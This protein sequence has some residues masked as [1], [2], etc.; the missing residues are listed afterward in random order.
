MPALRL[1][2]TVENAFGVCVLSWKR[3]RT[4]CLC[5]Y[6]RAEILWLPLY[7]REAPAL[8]GLIR[9]GELRESPIIGVPW[10]GL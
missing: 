5:G 8:K 2:E 3:E 9:K 6:G 10:T 7:G 4:E 1:N